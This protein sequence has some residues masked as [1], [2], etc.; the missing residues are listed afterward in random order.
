MSAEDRISAARV[1]ETG[2]SM[3]KRIVLLTT[4]TRGDVQ[5][6]TALALGLKRAGYD[7]CLAAPENFLT[8]I[9]RHGLETARCGSDFQAFMDGPEIQDFISANI[10]T[11]MRQAKS[12]TEKW[13]GSAI[14]DMVSASKG[15]DAIL[16]HPKL[17]F[18]TDISEATGLKAIL[19][20]LQPFTATSEF[21]V[22][23]LP[24][25]TLGGFL[26]RA[27]Y[28][29]MRLGRS[30]ASKEFDKWR[31]DWLGL[32]PSERFAYPFTVKGNPV[33]IL[34]GI[35]PSIVPRP[36]DW[37]ANVHLTGYWFLDDT[38]DWTPQAP[39]DAFLRDG[40]PPIYIGFGSMPVQNPE[41]LSRTLIEALKQT[42]LRAVIAR[43]W[44]DFN[45]AKSGDLPGSICV[46]DAAPHEHLFPRMSGVVH[47]GGAGTTIAGLRAGQPTLV[48]P[49]LVDQPFWGRRIADL[50]AGPP[51]LP[52]KSWTVERLAAS[53]KALTTKKSYANVAKALQREIALEDG[54]K[55]AV[56]CVREEIGGP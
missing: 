3:A 55:H 32:P 38:P 54:V 12:L 13:L 14:P 42:G 15:A 33:P 36:E 47:H 11:R 35:S 39:L 22:L 25:R 48:C 18:A 26:N 31:K 44:G 28:K 19:C 29:L 27:T 45:P 1:G 56:D 16:F 37:R 34:Y 40:P 30:F 20:A 24:W 10:I 50:G 51:P 41:A 49:F 43:G 46:I 23:T 7:V 6:F 53:L 4:G 2:I 17:D 52:P 5:P 8:E 9:A 21:P